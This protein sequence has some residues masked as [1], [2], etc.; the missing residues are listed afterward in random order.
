MQLRLH[1]HAIVFLFL[2]QH[3]LEALRVLFWQIHIPQHHFFH[4]NPVLR[5]P[6]CDLIRR[7]LSNF[8]PFRRKHIPHRIRRHNLPPDG[9]HNSR[10]NFLL[11]RLRQVRLHKIEPL[12]VNPVPHGDRQPQLQPFLCLH[13]KE[14]PLRILPPFALAQTGRKQLIASIE[15]LHP[16]YQRR[17][18]MRPRIERSCQR[19]LRL[20][21][22][23]PSHPARHDHNPLRQNQRQDCR[24][25]QQADPLP[26]HHRS[27]QSHPS[28]FRQQ[29]LLPKLH[30]QIS[31][32]R[33][34]SG[35]P[36][37]QQAAN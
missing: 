23:D 12:R 10:N 2:Q 4:H 27:P 37:Q 19:P 5:Q 18:H 15:Q 1:T 36:H 33:Q 25:S 17:N 29:Q 14:F 13:A 34:L 11:H 35:S 32:I 28:L 6:Q 21:H 30:H 16:V 20:T 8:F 26:P 3:G 22:A 7:L 24:H 31:V 9:G